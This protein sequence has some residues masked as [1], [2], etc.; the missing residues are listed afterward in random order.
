MMEFRVVRGSW[1]R[2][3]VRAPV[4]KSVRLGRRGCGCQ[5]PKMEGWG[6]GL[7]CREIRAAMMPIVNTSRAKGMRGVRVVGDVVA[8]VRSSSMNAPTAHSRLS[9]HGGGVQLS[10]ARSVVPAE[11]TRLSPAPTWI[12]LTTGM[13]IT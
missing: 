3:A 7:L 2:P 12:P 8:A 1:P 5:R 6:V 9:R 11:M 4:R 10:G 13:G